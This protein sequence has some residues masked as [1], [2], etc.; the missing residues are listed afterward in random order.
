MD[1]GEVVEQGTHKELFEL[2]GVYTS[3]YKKDQERLGLGHYG[4]KSSSE[5]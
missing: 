2:D 3:M 4:K 1:K 5:E